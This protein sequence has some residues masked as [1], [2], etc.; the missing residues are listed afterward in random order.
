VALHNYRYFVCL[1]YSATV[2]LIAAI[3]VAIT[4]FR[5]V[6]SSK[7]GS[8]VGFIDCVITVWEE[9]KLI[10]FLFYCFFLLVAVLLL[11]IY[12]TVISLHNLTTNE[13]VK[14]YYKDNPFDFGGFRNV[15]QIYLHPELVL[16]DGDDIILADYQPFGSYTSG[17]S[18]DEAF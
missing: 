7:Y 18:Y 1:L 12:H 17:R 16:A 6:A 8:N 4:I 2:F 13:H 5:Q 11:S 9:P 14:E 15:Q 3:S 10:A